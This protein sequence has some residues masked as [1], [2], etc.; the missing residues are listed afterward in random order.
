[1][2]RAA[3]VLRIR[4]D[5]VQDYIA[6]HARVWSEMRDTIT[7]SGI[8]NYTIFLRGSEAIGYLES[9]DLDA[10]WAFLANQDVNERWQT[11][12][13]EYLEERVSVEGPTLLEEIFRL[14]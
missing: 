2:E 5:H 6:A 10:A 4:P 14:D 13:A 3:F 1:M 9:D 12:M 11:T 8:R 7:A